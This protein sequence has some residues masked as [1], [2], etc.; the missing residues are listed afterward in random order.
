MTVCFFFLYSL[1]EPENSFLFFFFLKQLAGV[2][3]KSS[4]DGGQ[5]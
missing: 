4:T 5:A 2:Q 1:G 3:A